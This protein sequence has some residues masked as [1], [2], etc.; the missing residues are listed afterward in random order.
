MLTAR[1]V[2]RLT[3]LDEPHADHDRPRTRA[4]CVDGA[5]PC[6]FVGC[7]HHLFLDVDDHGAIRLNFPDIAPDELGESCS[8]DIAERVGCRW[9]RSPSC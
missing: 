8:L 4:E 2:A 5:R 7:R 6:P 1:D 9:T 3:V